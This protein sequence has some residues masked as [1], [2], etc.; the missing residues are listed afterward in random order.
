MGRL[1]AI[2]P[3][4]ALL[5]ILLEPGSPVRDTGAA[6]EVGAGGSVR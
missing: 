1:L 6:G 2:L 4:R 5:G 3:C